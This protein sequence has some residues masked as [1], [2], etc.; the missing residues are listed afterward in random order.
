[1]NEIKDNIEIKIGSEKNFGYFFF[2]LFLLIS[3]YPLIKGEKI[4]GW[5][6]ICSGFFIGATLFSPSL[7]KIP[8]YYWAKFGILLGKIISPIVMLI[9][10]LLGIAPVSVFLKIIRKDILKNNYDESLDTYWIKK[11]RIESMRNQF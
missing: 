2:T 7:L 6:L 5:S 11:E 8:N 10:Y 4:L 3:L 1:M 9:I